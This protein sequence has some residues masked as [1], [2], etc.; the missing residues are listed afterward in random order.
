MCKCSKQYRNSDVKKVK[1][2]LFSLAEKEWAADVKSKPGLRNYEIFK[3]NL[4]P[5]SYL[6]SVM[7]KFTYNSLRNLGLVYCPC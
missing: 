5:A 6:Q 7:S 1:S 4:Q 2:K 3:T